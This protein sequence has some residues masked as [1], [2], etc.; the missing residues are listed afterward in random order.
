MKILLLAGTGTIGSHIWKIL[1]D[2][3]YDIFI[4]SRSKR[5]TKEKICYYQGNAHDLNFLK[6][7]INEKHP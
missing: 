2:K 3:G 4:T 7:I 1:N 6:S 5:K